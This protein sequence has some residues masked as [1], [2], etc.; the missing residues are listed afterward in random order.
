[1]QAA[2]QPSPSGPQRGTLDVQSPTNLLQ[3]IRELTAEFER[4]LGEQLTVNPTD[5]AAMEHLIADGPLTP[6][7]LA[8][9]L[10]VTTAAITTSIDRLTAVGHVTRQPNPDDRRGIL[11]VPSP[12]SIQQAMGML[13]PM[14]MGI[15]RVLA[16]FDEQQQAVITSYL[17]K[18]VEVYE[19]HIPSSS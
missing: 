10:G 12:T 2:E 16:G 8:R 9:R 7:E 17:A 14:I 4:A 3:R 11:V 5:L 15:D 1:M 6:T 13:L 18:V 19:N